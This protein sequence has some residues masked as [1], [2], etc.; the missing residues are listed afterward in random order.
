VV[1]GVIQADEAAGLGDDLYLHLVGRDGCW[2]EHT[3]A[4]DA[5]LVDDAVFT[6]CGP[7]SS[8][9]SVICQ[10][11]HPL[12]GIVQG[13]LRL[14]GQLSSFLRW[15]RATLIMTELAGRLDTAFVDEQ[16]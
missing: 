14:H 1:G 11:L 15:S 3:L 13:R 16:Q 5:G 12:T 8:W 10:Q 4:A 9:K 7:Y 6:I 2:S